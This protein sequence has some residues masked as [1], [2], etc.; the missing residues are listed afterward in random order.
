MK[1]LEK[2]FTVLN[3]TEQKTF[4]APSPKECIDYIVLLKGEKRKAPKVQEREVINEPVASD[5]RPVKVVVSL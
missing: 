4:P 1:R 5:H 3:D 2:D